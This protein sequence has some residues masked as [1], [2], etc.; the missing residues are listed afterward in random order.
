MVYNLFRRFAYSTPRDWPIVVVYS[1]MNPTRGALQHRSRTTTTQ[2]QR[3]SSSPM[4]P[5]RASLPV[6]NLHSLL[7]PPSPPEPYPRTPPSFSPTPPIRSIRTSPGI[8]SQKFART[9]LNFSSIT[10]SPSRG[11]TLSS[12]IRAAQIQ[13]VKLQVFAKWSRRASRMRWKC[14]WVFSTGWMGLTHRRPRI[15]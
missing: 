6:L 1:K 2:S 8:F 9:F 3:F 5:C 13:V 7:Y 12:R 10:P 15:S 11:G 14:L 4:V